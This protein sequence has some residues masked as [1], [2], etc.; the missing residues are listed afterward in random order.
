MNSEEKFNELIKGCGKEAY[1]IEENED[2]VLCGEDRT[3][4]KNGE[5]IKFFC[6]ECENKIKSLREELTNKTYGCKEFV[7][8]WNRYCGQ[9]EDLKHSEHIILCPSCQVEREKDQEIIKK[10]DE[11]IQECLYNIQSTEGD[12]I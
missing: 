8:F 4:K 3:R 9:F 11:E 10:I 1:F 7:E 5:V 12:L 2:L 6:Y